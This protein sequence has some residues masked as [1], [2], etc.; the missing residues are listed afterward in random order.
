MRHCQPRH[1]HSHLHRTCCIY[2]S[3]AQ[4][5]PRTGRVMER[6][7]T[8]LQAQEDIAA[9]YSKSYLQSPQVTLTLVKSGQRVT[10]NGAV[11][12]PSVL[13]LESTVTLSMAIAESGGLSELGDSARV[14]VARPT[15]QQV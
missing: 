9:R 12:K 13:S 5:H 15:G 7:K 6:R 11:K 1:P 2:C 8:I 10:V 3:R 14:H 4:A